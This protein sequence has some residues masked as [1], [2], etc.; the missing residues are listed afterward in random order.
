[1]GKKILC[2]DD[3][4]T[5]QRLVQNIL[6]QDGNEVLVADN[7]SVALAMADPSVDLYLVDVNMPVMDGFEFVSALKKRTE[8]PARPVVFVT[9]ESNEEV[10]SRGKSLGAAGWMV[11]PFDAPALSKVVAMLTG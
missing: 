1:M 7:G 8:L 2:V 3:S 4:I 11:K 10:R 9:T 6:S 5:I